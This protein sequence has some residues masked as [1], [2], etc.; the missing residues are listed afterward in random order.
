MQIIPDQ[1][2]VDELMVHLEDA[3][4]GRGLSF[5]ALPPNHI[6]RSDSVHLSDLDLCITQKFWEKVISG[7]GEKQKI[8]PR[9]L[10][11]MLTGVG[12]EMYLTGTVSHTTVGMGKLFDMNGITISMTP[13]YKTTVDDLAEIKT[14]RMYPEKGTG[15]PAKHGFSTSWLRRMQGYAIGYGLDHYRL[16]ILYI[17]AASL[18]GFTFEYD[19][20]GEQEK[21]LN[22]FMYPRAKALREALDQFNE[23]GIRKPPEP[24]AYNDAWQCLRCPFNFICEASKVAGNYIPSTW[25][26]KDQYMEV[27]PS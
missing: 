4:M 27:V 10:L 7:S 25:Q 6:S 17:G 19:I 13:D 1:P 18:V 5:T 11:Y 16:A 22:E 3:L 8:D 26:H 21:F 2:L 24:F 12:F 9:N 14:T 20:P 15:I 23:S